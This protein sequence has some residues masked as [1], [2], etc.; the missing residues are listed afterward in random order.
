MF[1]SIYPWGK[2]LG[3]E[4]GTVLFF[5]VPALTAWFVIVKNMSGFARAEQ[6]VLS[7]AKGFEGKLCRTDVFI[8]FLIVP[9]CGLSS[10]LSSL[11]IALLM[12]ISRTNQMATAVV[13]LPL[14]WGILGSWVVMSQRRV[15]LA[16]LL[17]CAAGSS[18]A[19][20]FTQ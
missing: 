8:F 17:L 2:A 19:L 5:A 11:A 14:F 13:L 3:F 15:P 9:L 10:L 4:Y 12:P 7:T 6:G 20:I 1:A 18:A 16:G